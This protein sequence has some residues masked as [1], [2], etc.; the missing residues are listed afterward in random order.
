MCMRIFSEAW[1][2]AL[3]ATGFHSYNQVDNQRESPENR[4]YLNLNM[5][6]EGTFLAIETK[7]KQYSIGSEKTGCF[8]TTCCPFS[9]TCLLDISQR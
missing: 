6:I 2:L 9:K 7:S 3:Q 5:F 4:L 8:S 1:A